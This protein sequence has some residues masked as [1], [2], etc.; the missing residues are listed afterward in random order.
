MHHNKDGGEFKKIININY[1]AVNAY[2]YC[3]RLTLIIWGGTLCLAWGAYESDNDQLLHARGKAFVH[4]VE[5]LQQVKAKISEPPTNDI[6]IKTVSFCLPDSVSLPPTEYNIHG[7]ASATPEITRC[8]A[9]I[10]KE[11]EQAKISPEVFL[12]CRTESMA[13][14]IPGSPLAVKYPRQELFPDSKNAAMTLAFRRTEMDTK[15]STPVSLSSYHGNFISSVDIVRVSGFEVRKNMVG[16]PL[17]ADLKEITIMARPAPVTESIMRC[18]A[19]AFKEPEN[20]NIPAG[21]LLTCRVADMPKADFRKSLTLKGPQKEL[22]VSLSP[23]VTLAFRKT[24]MDTLLPAKTILLTSSREGSVNFANTIPASCFEVRRN[25]TG[26]QFPDMKEITILTKAILPADNIR[27]PIN[28]ARSKDYSGGISAGVLQITPLSINTESVL[29]AWAGNSLASIPSIPAIKLN[30]VAFQDRGWSINPVL[31]SYRSVRAFG[32]ANSSADISAGFE[33]R[34]NTGEPL[35]L[36]SDKKEIKIMAKAIALEDRSSID[37]ICVSSRFDS[38]L[39]NNRLIAPL[40]IDATFVL[41]AWANN[42]MVAVPPVPAIELNRTAFQDATP[43]A[44]PILVAYHH[45]D[46]SD[47]VSSINNTLSGFKIRRTS[48]DAYL[49]E[50]NEITITAKPIV[51]GDNVSSPI[52]IICAD[53]ISGGSSENN[54]QTAPLRLNAKSVLEAWASSALISV[55]A[56]PKLNVTVLD[57]PAS[58]VNPIFIPRY[59]ADIFALNKANAAPI[60]LNGLKI[61]DVLSVQIRQIIFA[62]NLAKTSVRSPCT[63]TLRRSDLA[64]PQAI[65]RL[66]ISG[67]MDEVRSGRINKRN[68]EIRA[69]LVQFLGDNPLGPTSQQVFTMILENFPGNALRRKIASLQ[70]WAQE[71]ASGRYAPIIGYHIMHQFY[72][73]KDYDA[74]IQFAESFLEKTKEFNDRVSFL[75]ALCYAQKNNT[76]AALNVLQKIQHDFPDSPMAPESVFLYAWIFYEDGNLAE[77]K[78]ILKE[79]TAKYPNSPSA[80]KAA[81]LLEAINQ[82]NGLAALK[83]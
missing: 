20:P 11:P 47:S 77:A 15:L 63:L 55:P 52:K 35:L 14:T 60:H 71:Y 48:P 57:N 50:L 16:T 44:K 1:S 25:L 72:R 73:N 22:F 31:V 27:P 78:T 79:L 4:T 23:V 29:R 26:T 68:P 75:Q 6:L 76:T 45:E 83:Q 54:F 70:A 33:I 17:I 74:A 66:L 69:Q 58:S 34:K 62:S 65:D 82:K 28:L 61:N 8:C 18:C 13:V 24:E 37:L 51:S 32:S 10:F 80:G 42:S 38:A 39:A 56:A 53:N 43:S 5:L 9:I 30:T 36:Y 21:M 12:T 7:P 2:K 49:P 67:I 3:R 19:I 46:I 40:N 59:S 81:K 64:I 41:Q